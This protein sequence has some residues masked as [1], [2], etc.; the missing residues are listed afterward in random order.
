MS[1]A[2]MEAIHLSIAMATWCPKPEWHKNQNLA[3]VVKH[4]GVSLP[5]ERT[6]SFKFSLHLSGHPPAA[7]DS[8]HSFRESLNLRM[9]KTLRRVL[10]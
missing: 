9:A 7:A 2:L 1:V 3:I 5:T 4:L 10:L 6:P 8:Q